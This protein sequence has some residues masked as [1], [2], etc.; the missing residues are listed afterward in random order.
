M[1]V[2]SC[3][4]PVGDVVH[5][6][7]TGS[8]RCRRRASR[9][10]CDPPGRRAWSRR[11]RRR[12]R[13]RRRWRRRGRAGRRTDRASSRAATPRRPAWRAGAGAPARRRRGRRGG[14]HS[15]SA[16]ARPVTMSASIVTSRRDGGAAAVSDGA[17]MA[18]SGAGD[19][20]GRRDGQLGDDRTQNPTEFSQQL[21]RL[22]RT[23]VMSTFEPLSVAPDESSRGPSTSTSSGPRC[24]STTRRPTRLAA[25]RRRHARRR[26][27]GTPSTCPPTLDPERRRGG[28]PVRLPRTGR[29]S[30]VAGRRTGR[31]ARRVGPDAP[32]LRALRHA[33][34][35][36]GR[37]AVDALPGVRAV[38]V[39]AP[40]PGDD[41]ARH[42]GRRRPRPGGVAGPGRAVEGADVLLPG[43]V[44]RARRVAGGR[45]RARGQ[46]GGR[47]DGRRRHATAAASR[48]RSRTA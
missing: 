24:G 32:L 38:G 20:R 2:A 45:R 17:V 42:P 48:G 16:A 14:R 21:A 37:R 46:R 6:A 43:R 47:P 31:A 4:R 33:D 11:A 28:R 19:R 9:A 13:R 25:P 15:A 41:H 30:G 39:P 29:R 44:R 3:A 35:A 27:A 8:S 40:R 7:R 26:R 12:R 5:D 36:G 18:D 1:L 22:V 10:R 34:R 23:A